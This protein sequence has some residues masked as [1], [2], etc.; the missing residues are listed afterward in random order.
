MI[1]WFLVFINVTFFSATKT[2]DSLQGL[3]TKLC[4]M[5]ANLAELLLF[6]FT[7]KESGCRT[8]G[9]RVKQTKT[10]PEQL[11]RPLPPYPL[12]TQARRLPPRRT[13]DR[14]LQKE[15]W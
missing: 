6:F 3:G 9:R 11:A 10:P 13:A 2:P 14:W 12:A 7:P 15:G 1:V 8:D 4:G 5:R